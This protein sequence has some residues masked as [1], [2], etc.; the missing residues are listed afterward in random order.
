MEVVL[1]WA[2]NE[3]TSII[4]NIRKGYFMLPKECPASS[5]FGCLYS[6]ICRYDRTRLAQKEGVL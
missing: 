1:S 2:G 5:M 4:N 6:G 3:A